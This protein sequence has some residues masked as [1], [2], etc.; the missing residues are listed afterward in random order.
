MGIVSYR[1]PTGGFAMP[2]PAD[3]ERAEDVQA[4]LAL[5]AVEPERAGGGFRANLVVTIE[6][7]A[8]GT[9]LDGWQASAD[10][11]LIAALSGYLLLDRERLDRDGRG[12][13]RR[14]AHHVRE[15]TG[16]ITM[17]QWTTVDGEQGFTLT[18][19]A[20]TLEYDG[21]AE[22]FAGIADG[23]HLGR[24]PDEVRR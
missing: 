4:G 23:F 3:W 15:D 21:L 1:H 11:E 19:S 24:A 13:I 14:L 9:D 16:S 18:A 12:V 2:L 7:L 20:A 5:I 6:P 10:Q 22:A 17:E 8:A